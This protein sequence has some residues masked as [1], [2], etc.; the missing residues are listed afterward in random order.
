ME[1]QEPMFLIGIP[2][3]TAFSSWQRLNALK[4]DPEVVRREYI[5]AMVHMQFVCELYRVQMDSGRYFL[6]ASSRS[7][8]MEGELRR[9]V[10]ERPTCATPE[11]RSV[12]IRA[13]STRRQPS[14]KAHGM[15]VQRR[16]DH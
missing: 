7:E 12:Q 2:M 10:A 3:C 15:D 5:K 13:A 9:R 8:L 1:E 16:K 4:R 14:E 11:W 6:H